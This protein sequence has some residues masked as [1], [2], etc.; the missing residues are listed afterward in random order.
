M[1]V[2]VGDASPRQAQGHTGDSCVKWKHSLSDVS[3]SPI[4]RGQYADASKEL[5]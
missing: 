3:T 5:R 1:I 4:R 2:S